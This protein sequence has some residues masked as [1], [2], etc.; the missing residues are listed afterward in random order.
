MVKHC[1]LTQGQELGTHSEILITHTTCFFGSS[2]HTASLDQAHT[3]SV[4]SPFLAF[5]CLVPNHRVLIQLEYLQPSMSDTEI[6]L[7]KTCSGLR[8]RE[9]VPCV[10]QKRANQTSRKF[11][12][13]CY[14][15]FPR[16]T[17]WR[18]CSGLRIRE[19]VPC[20]TQKLARSS[21][22]V[23]RLRTTCWFT[24]LSKTVS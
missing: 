12:S 8:I 17:W 4:P 22:G 21:R 6:V 10:T 23:A 9:R 18:T 1:A 14:P 7:P 5:D 2:T 11:S 13:P 15:S 16:M 3:Q 24:N 19:S 20:V